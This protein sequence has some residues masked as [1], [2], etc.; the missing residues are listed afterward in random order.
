MSKIS[1]KTAKRTRRHGRIRSKVAGTADKPRLAVYRSNTAIY[2]QLI[3]DVKGATLAAADSRTAKG[4]N[5]RARARAVGSAIAEAAKKAG[6]SK[7]VFDRGG[8]LYT[9]SVKELAE[10]AREAGLIF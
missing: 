5:A 1:I 8:F 2:A 7:V 3:D 10:G 4:E 6:V 9:G